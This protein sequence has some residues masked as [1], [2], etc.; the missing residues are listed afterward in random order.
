MLKYYV[1]RTAYITFVTMNFKDTRFY[2]QRYTNY[3]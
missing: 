2:I 1:T 3:I